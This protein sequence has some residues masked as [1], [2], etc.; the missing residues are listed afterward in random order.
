MGIFNRMSAGVSKEELFWKWFTAS[1]RQLMAVKTAREPI[2]DELHRRLKSIEKNLVFLFGP[3]KD[4][5]RE[6][7]VS[8]D[9]IRAAFPAVQALVAAAPDVPGWKIIAFRPA[10]GVFGGLDFGGR[11]FT[12]D[13]FWFTA[14][15]GI[16]PRGPGIGLTIY[17]RGLTKQKDDPALSAAFIMLDHA[18]G[19]YVVE[20]KLGAL[21]FE[22]LPVDPLGHGLRPFAELPAVMENL[23]PDL[24]KN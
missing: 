2:C 8:A 14:H 1:S 16:G 17:V 7:I 15:L 18:L 4:G 12:Q 5:R 13:D 24:G 21:S 20:T 10:T 3:V 23:G 22:Q 11:R 9:G 19:E 6:F